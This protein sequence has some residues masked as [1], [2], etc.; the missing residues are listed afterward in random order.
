MDG[1]LTTKFLLLAILIVASGFFSSSE[2]AL[3]SLGLPRVR[4][5][6]KSGRKSME[7]AQS[8]LTSPT[9]LISTL[10]I[11]NEIVNAAIGIVGASIVY[12]LFSDR[13]SPD[14]LQWAAIALVFPFVL[15]L[16]DIVPKAIGIKLAERW[17]PHVALPLHWFSIW[18]AP[19]RNLL[20]W[21]PDRIV[22]L[23][24]GRGKPSSSVSEDLF[25]SLVDA[26]REEGV[27]DAQEQKLIH[28]VFQL[29]DVEVS[30]IMT[31]KGAVSALFSDVTVGE[32]MLLLEADRFSR[33]PLLDRTTG[34]V[35]GVLYAKDLL[36]TEELDRNG[37]VSTYGRP[38]LEVSPS[39]HAMELFSK[40]RSRRMHFAVVTSGEAKM[41]GVV[42]LDDVLEEVFGRIRD[43]R[44]LEEGQSSKSS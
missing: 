5:L 11:G 4:R 18:T 20:V 2:A 41:I 38:A 13:L 24:G 3:F 26:G 8:L 12:D 7:A 17:I 37:P 23:F 36:A 14:H 43:E 42:T 27:L 25:R 29:D 33:F 9:K 21:I 10:L 16:G 35:S 28:N 34:R 6:R 22:T 39:I 44:D 30:T 40:F 32:A 19:I 31:P 15:I 1:A